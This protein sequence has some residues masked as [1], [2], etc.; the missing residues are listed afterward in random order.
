MDI[1]IPQTPPLKRAS[2]ITP[3]KG[4][5][6]HFLKDI[7]VAEHIATLVTPENGD[8]LIEIGSGKGQITIP[9]LLEIKKAEIQCDFLA[10]EK[11]NTLKEALL[12]TLEKLELSNMLVFEGDDALKDIPHVFHRANER[13]I[14]LFG[15]IPYY[16]TGKLFRIIWNLEKTPQKSVFMVQKE[17]AERMVG[18][19]GQENRL[20]VFIKF[21]GTPTIALLVPKKSFSP[22]PKV[23]SAVIVIEKNNEQYPHLK[24][25]YEI[26]AN[27]L[28][29]QPRKIASNNLAM[30]FK[31]DLHPKKSAENFL[32]E[33][34]IVLNARAAEIPVSTLIRMAE[35]LYNKRNGAGKK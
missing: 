32:E 13:K 17:V 29:S 14:T 30:L 8:F 21:W 5:G 22:P 12:E 1:S 15:N 16:I 6:Q 11:D 2:G 10:I 18:G 20:S 26:L 7:R 3:K 23:D 9:I 34:G 28:F 33:F 31:D 24:E 27:I 25:I 35:V 19:K 4:L